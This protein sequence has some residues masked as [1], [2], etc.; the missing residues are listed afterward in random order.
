MRNKMKL[1]NILGKEEQVEDMNPPRTKGEQVDNIKLPR[2]EG[3][4]MRLTSMTDDSDSLLRMV[5]IM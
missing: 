4:I 5:G 1:W 3:V 2:K